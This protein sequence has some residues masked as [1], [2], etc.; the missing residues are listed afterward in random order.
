MKLRKRQSLKIRIR[1]HQRKIT[2]NIKTLIHL[3]RQVLK[4]KGLRNAELSIVF[5]GKQRIRALN[6]KFRKK[7]RPTDVLAFSMREGEDARLHPQVLG[8]VVIC[9]Q[10]AKE[11]ARTYHHTTGQ[12]IELYLIHGLLH[13][14]GYDDSRAKSRALM[15]KEQLM[16]LREAIKQEN[17]LRR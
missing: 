8:D 7:D 6:K 10:I 12:E 13:L 15:E 3:A 16:I 9:P 2:I 11:A 17:R 1:N 4:R 14:L 5:V